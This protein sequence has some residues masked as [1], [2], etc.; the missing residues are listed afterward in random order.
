MAIPFVLAELLPQTPTFLD[1]LIPHSGLTMR[2]WTLEEYHRMSYPVIFG[3]EE[4]TELIYGEVM[5][6]HEGVPRVFTREE[7]YRLSKYGILKPEE[8]T[9][10]IYGRVILHISLLGRPHSIAISKAVDIFKV[11]FGSGHSVE[12]QIPLHLS[13]LLDPEP[14][15]LVL[16]GSSDD[17]SDAPTSA[18]VLLLLEVSDSTLRFDRSVKATMYATDGVRDYWLLN[19]R[20]RT[21]EVY[22]QPEEG[23]YLNLDVYHEGEAVAPLAAPNRLVRV[24]DLLPLI[25]TNP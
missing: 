15:V 1:D 2:R 3:P 21:L 19:L 9:E 13:N 17:Y 20:S 5:V 18:D 16:P 10:L 7:Y 25:R 6:L 12:S 14:D 11:L 23:L 4:R 24:A 8:R 22:R